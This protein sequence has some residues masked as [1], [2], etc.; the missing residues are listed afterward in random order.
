MVVWELKERALKGA[1][2]L[3]GTLSA[4]FHL[5]SLLVLLPSGSWTHPLGPPVLGVR[6]L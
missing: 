4:V 6:F 3:I 2:Q 5:D 1:R